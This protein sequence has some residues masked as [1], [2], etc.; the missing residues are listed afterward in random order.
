MRHRAVFFDFGGTLFS[1][2]EVRPYFDRM[3]HELATS[4][5]ITAPMEEI[6]R[7]YRTAIAKK[8][9]EFLPRLAAPLLDAAARLRDPL[10][11]IRSAVYDAGFRGSFSIKTVGPALL[12]DEISYGDLEIQG[13]DL[14]SAAYEEMI[15]ID[16]ARERYEEIRESLLEYCRLDTWTMVLLV[17]WLRAQDGA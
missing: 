3:L 6:R 12:G 9:A 16:P 13:G 4:H 14:A 11:L 17:R 7:I 5:A 1:Y 2:A 10:A 8:M 15:A